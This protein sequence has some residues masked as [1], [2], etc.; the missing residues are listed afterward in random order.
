M[1]CTHTFPCTLP[2]TDADALNR[3]LYT[4]ALVEHYRIY[5][6]TGHWLSGDGLEKL[7]DLYETQE[8]R[9]RLLHAHSVDA[10]EQGF[11]KACKTAQGC[12]KRGLATRYPYKRK[13]YRTTVWKNTGFRVKEGV[14][15]LALARGHEP[16]RVGLPS[17]L[18]AL[19]K[20]ALVELRLGIRVNAAGQNNWVV[21][22][23]RA[24]DS[25]RLCR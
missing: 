24:R 12:R 15:L 7:V 25:I 1:I 6:Q 22:I 14:L 19:P 2:R 9:E 5:R 10:A 3:R 4:R 18:A 17:H 23:N 16:L 13:V 11:P 8:G 20:E 21:T